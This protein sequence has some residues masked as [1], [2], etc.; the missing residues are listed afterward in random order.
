MTTAGRS[1]GLQAVEC[2]VTSRSERQAQNEGAGHAEDRYRHSSCSQR[3]R[4]STPVR[5]SLRYTYAAPLGA[6]GWV[7]RFWRKPHDIAARWLVQPTTLAQPRGRVRVCARGRT[8]TRGG[9]RRD[10]AESR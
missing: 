9:R 10:G 8:D 4:L 6:G 5:R 7:T 3:F 2:L 1:K